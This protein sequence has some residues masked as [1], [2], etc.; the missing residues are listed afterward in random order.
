[1]KIKPNRCCPYLFARFARRSSHI[2]EPAFLTIIRK[3]LRQST[4]AAFFRREG[5]QGERGP[6]ERRDWPEPGAVGRLGPEAL[7]GRADA[8]D[9]SHTHDRP[10][11]CGHAS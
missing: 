7:R 4:P 10:F 11:L 2:M 9:R 8:R 3:P 1:M 6:L 5:R